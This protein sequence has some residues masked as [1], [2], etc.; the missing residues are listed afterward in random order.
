MPIIYSSHPTG[1]D[2]STCTSTVQEVI[3]VIDSSLDTVTIAYQGPQGIQGTQGTQGTTG[4]TGAQGVQGIQGLQGL[5][6]W[7]TF[8]TYSTTPPLTP[9]V[10]DRWVDSSDGTSYTYT[11]DGNTYQWVELNAIGYQGLQGIQG[12]QG[13]QG[14][15]GTQGAT[16]S[17]GV[18][19]PQGAVGSQGV[20]GP[21]G[22]V[23]SQGTQGPVG[24]QGAQ[25]PQ[26]IT[27]SVSSASSLTLTGA[28]SGTT[29]LSPVA[30]AS[31]TATVP[32]GTYNL[33][34]DTISNAGSVTALS[35]IPTSATVPTNGLYLP[36]ANTIAL[37]TNSTSRL[38]INSDGNIG[39]PSLST[40]IGLRF[41]IPITGATTAQ[42]IYMRSV[43]QSGVTT[44]A[45][46]IGSSLQTVGGVAFNAVIQFLAQGTTLA[47]GSSILNHYAFSVDSSIA[48][49]T[50]NYAYQGGLNT[51]ATATVTAATGDGTTVTYTASNDF[52]PGLVVSITNLGI[53]SGSSLNLTSVTINSASSTQ[54]TVLNATVG[55]AS[56]TGTA[57]VVRN[58]WNLYLGGTAANYLAGALGIGSTPATAT[59][60]TVQKNMTGATNAYGIFNGGTVQSD[61]TA[62]AY[63]YRAYAQTQAASFTLTNLTHF[64]AS[65]GTFGAGSSVTN[66]YG[67][68]VFNTLT[69]ATNNYGFYGQLAAATGVWNLYMAG[70][71]NNYLAGALGIGGLGIQGATTLTIGKNITGSTDARGV[72]VNGIIQSDVTATARNFLSNPSTQAAAFTLGALYHFQAAQGTIGAGSAVTTQIGFYASSLSGATNNRGFQSDLA[73]GTGVWNLYM[74]G[75]AANYVAGVFNVGTNSLNLGNGGVA[76]QLAVYTTATTTVGAVIRGAASQTANLQEW[77]NSSGTNLAKVDASGNLT[78]VNLT[79]TGTLARPAPTTTT[80]ASYSAT[81]TETYL[82]TNVAGTCT[83]TLPTASTNSGRIITIKTITAQLVISA[84][85]NVVPL[86]SATAGTAILAATAGKWAELVSDGTNWII[87]SGN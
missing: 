87:M 27:G 78:A 84:S 5:Q 35:F 28:T 19:G 12:L 22:A 52:A 70:T 37:S 85:S 62:G 32:A 75:T 73:S 33:I 38:Q 86:I 67:F 65:Q 34:G 20:Q 31:G 72:T 47:T 8:Y 29:I 50:N 25:G 77:Q 36:A 10:G 3:S 64:Y 40:T 74:S 54:F 61:V 79:L 82:I 80:S 56:G 14:I 42:G 48:Q 1:C 18:Q 69:G 39:L 7:G 26:G 53:S 6:G 63:Y 49:G 4:N 13:P 68:Y 11:F 15:Q 2:C 81:A 71:A 60:L 17:Q 30:V 9:A 41:G 76:A 16:G 46:G 57:T 24:S 23:G 83:V 21:Q 43:I 51:S 58:N 59:T 44:Q 55:V 45:V 66:Q